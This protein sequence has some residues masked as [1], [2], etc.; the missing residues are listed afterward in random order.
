MD[1]LL[2]IAFQNLLR[3]APDGKLIKKECRKLNNKYVYFL[4]ME[5]TIQSIK[6]VYLGYYYSDSNGSIQFLCYTSR[7]LL[8]QYQTD[9]ESLLNGFVISE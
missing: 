6:F 3:V 5:G 1:N 9:L 7:N 2:D 8:N 4:Q